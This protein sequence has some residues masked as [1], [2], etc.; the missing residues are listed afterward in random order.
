MKGR[1]A[2]AMTASTDSCGWLKLRA[3]P[4]RTLVAVTNTFSASQLLTRSKSTSRTSRSRS[5]LMSSGL[6]SYGENCRVNCSKN[7]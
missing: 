4:V 5:G 1:Q 7:R 3:R 6:S 2:E